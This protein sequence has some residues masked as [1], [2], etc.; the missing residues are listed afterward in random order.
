MRTNLLINKETAK[1]RERKNTFSDK[2]S[3]VRGKPGIVFSC[4]KE[5]FRVP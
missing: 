4:C 2:Q 3:G 5:P 1:L